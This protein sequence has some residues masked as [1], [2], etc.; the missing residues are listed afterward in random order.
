MAVL[1]GV[2]GVRALAAL[3]LWAAV[4]G[5]IEGWFAAHEATEPSWW[6]VTSTVLGSVLVF[7]WYVADSDNRSFRRGPFLNGL[8]AALAVFAVPVYL[9]LSRPRGARAPAL[10]RAT[11]FFALM[12]GVGAACEFTV[13]AMI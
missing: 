9:A 10:G 3:M 11:A 8:M 7:A 4:N 12:L 2:P 5:A 6:L 1:S 13:R